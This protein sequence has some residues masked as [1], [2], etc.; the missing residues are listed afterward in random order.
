VV[1]SEVLQYLIEEA[2]VTL[3]Y[4][5]L[6]GIKIEDNANNYKWVWAKC[7][8]K[9]KQRLQEKTQ[10]LLRDIEQEN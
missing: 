10:E 9:Y 1:F 8:E 4:Y 5:Y 2:D 6:D 3:E 7:M